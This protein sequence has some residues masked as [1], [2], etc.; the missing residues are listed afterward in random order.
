MGWKPTGSQ[1]AKKNG[2]RRYWTGMIVWS[3]GTAVLWIG[4]AAWRMLTLIRRT[5][6]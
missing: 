4:V 3:A 1:G 5:S 2:M 6:R